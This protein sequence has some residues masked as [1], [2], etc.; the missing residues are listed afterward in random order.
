MQRMEN[1]V[2][3][4]SDENQIEVNKIGAANR[5]IFVSGW[6]PFIGW[7]CGIAFGWRYIGYPVCATVL[8]AVGAPVE[9]PQIPD[10]GDLSTVLYGLLGLGAMRTYEKRVGAAK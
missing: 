6:R 8:S 7:V 10:W 9:L 3:T 4:G 2:L 5:S 1:E